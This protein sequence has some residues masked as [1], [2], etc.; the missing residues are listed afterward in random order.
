VLVIGNGF[1]GQATTMVGKESQDVVL[2][3]PA[4]HWLR[5]PMPS[6]NV[7]DP[8][9]VSTASKNPS[10]RRYRS[11]VPSLLVQAPPLAIEPATPGFI[12]T[13]NLQV[14]FPGT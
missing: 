8:C 9:R 4:R 14:P 2:A 11:S 5:L 3:S 1:F 6:A 7:I 10:V 12:S 13:I